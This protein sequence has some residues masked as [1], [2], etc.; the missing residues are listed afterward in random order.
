MIS[1][2]DIEPLNLKMSGIFLRRIMNLYIFS[3]ESGVF[4]KKH[5]VVFVFAGIV[6]TDKNIV[7]K[8]MNKYINVERHIKRK[9]NMPKDIELKATMLNED[10]KRKLLRSI[11]CD[12]RFFVVINQEKVF[13]RI[14]DDKKSKQRYLDYAYKMGIKRMLEKM[15]VDLSQIHNLYIYC[16]EHTIASNGVYDLKTGIYRELKIGTENFEYNF[17]TKPILPNL[18]TVTV[19]YCD[20]KENALIRY[21]DILANRLFNILR[22]SKAVENKKDIITRLP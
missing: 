21:T 13:D 17:I 2:S 1:T 11:K 15:G 8:S 12:R 4:D 10:N 18:Q 19:T 5:N 3:D 6:F 9:L 20:S 16:D 7:L 22:S 14:F